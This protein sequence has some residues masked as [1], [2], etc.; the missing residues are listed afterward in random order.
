MTMNKIFTG[1]IAFVAGVALS[2]GSAFATSGYKSGDPARM[3]LV[4]YYETGPMKATIIGIQNMSPQEA[5]T[6]GKHAAVAGAKRALEKAQADPTTSLDVLA[7][8]EK[9]VADAEAVVNTEHI[10]VMVNVYDAMGMMMDG[11]TTTLCLAEHQFGHVVLQGSSSEMADYDQSAVLSVMDGDIPEYGYVKISA[12]VT[13]YD[14]C[15]ATSPDGL[16]RIPTPMTTDEG[17]DA[18][19]VNPSS[20]SVAAWTIIQDTG[21]GFFGTEVPTA[22]ISTS[23]ALSI[24]ADTDGTFTEVLTGAAATRIMLDAEIACYSR[25]AAD[26]ASATGELTDPTADPNTSVTPGAAP[27]TGGLFNQAKCGLIPERHDNSRW[28]RNTTDAPA[29]KGI[30]SIVDPSTISATTP[31]A[32][33]IGSATPRAHVMARYDAG[34]ESIVHVWLANG[35]DMDDTKPSEQRMLDVVVKCEDGE[36]MMDEDID[37][38]PGPIKVPAPDMVTMIDPNGDDLADYTGMCSGDRGALQITM[39]DGSAAGMVFTHISQMMGHYRMNFPGYSMANPATCWSMTAAA[40][41]TN[42]D[43]EINADTETA[44]DVNGD[45]ATDIEDITAARVNACS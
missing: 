29:R 32:E 5:D 14:G 45:G 39:P 31:L 10:F 20:N 41:D 40:G 18:T 24:R 16:K 28:L 38:N 37:G 35:M 44:V 12:G 25:P 15:T 19:A 6:A 11:A 27:Y 1:L 36:V 8:L 4:P 43:G 3:K 22:T 34:D 26:L 42:G 9:N 7:R 17:D 21:D 2:A 23:A 13:K 30:L 33:P